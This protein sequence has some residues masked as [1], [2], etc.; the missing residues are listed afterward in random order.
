MTKDI[1]VL[2]VGKEDWSSTL[3]LPERVEWQFCPSTAIDAFLEKKAERK[4]QQAPEDKTPVSIYFHAVMITDS[5]TESQLECLED[6]VDPYTVFVDKQVNL[7]KEDSKG[8]LARKRIRIIDFSTNRQEKITWLSNNIYPGFYGAKLKTGDLDISPI[9]KG[10][11]TYDGHVSTNVEGHF[12]EDFRQVA[13]FR[14]S[15]NTNHCA[16]EIWQEYMKTPGCQIQLRIDKLQRGSLYTVLETL[17]LDEA[18][19]EKPY[20]LEKEDEVGFYAISIW[21]K[22]EGRIQLG[23]LHYRFSRQGL[24]QF[25]PG[26]ERFADRKRQ[27]VISYFHPGDMKPPLNVYF[28][29]YRSAEGFE[30]YFMMRRMNAPFVLIGDP[31][32]EGGGF[33]TGTPELES[34]IERVI[35]EALD[36]LGFSSDQ[37]ILSGLSMGTFGALYY[38]SSF[39]P[40]AV[41][42]GK[43]FTNVGDTAKALKL[44]RPNEFATS[45]DILLNMTGG[46]SEWDIQVL[47]DYFWKKFEKARFDRTTFAIAYMEHDDYDNTAYERLVTY[48]TQRNIHIYGKGYL[49]RHNDNSRAINAWFINQYQTILREDF[50]R[51]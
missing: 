48:A 27:E 14:Y 9:F 35:Q 49:G 23:P 17:Q 37:L 2:Q 39:E 40:H 3:E 31:R 28:S 45:L 42:V 33:Y 34:C 8:F 41:I 20:V 4:A 38:A 43:P 13:T 24:G 22:G 12:G 16:Q 36:Y 15:L 6:S 51:K 30:G 10:K 18:D 44:K 50:G 25:L 47:N 29:G 5:V 7:T 19:M 1:I 46:S 26:G 32:L 11:V 21:A